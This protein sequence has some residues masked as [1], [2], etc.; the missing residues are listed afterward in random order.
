MWRSRLFWRL[1]LTTD[2][3]ITG[4]ANLNTIWTNA[5]ALVW[6]WGGGGVGWWW[7]WRK[8][9]WQW[10]RWWWWGSRW[11][12]WW[13][14]CQFKHHHPLLHTADQVQSEPFLPSYIFL[15]AISPFNIRIMC[16][17]D[18][19]I[20]SNIPL[21]HLQDLELNYSPFLATGESYYPSVHLLTMYTWPTQLQFERHYCIQ[22]KNPNTRDISTHTR[23][24]Q[25]RITQKHIH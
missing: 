4:R 9:S 23:V 19:R 6:R 21:Y 12:W 7:W 2:E 15:C 18:S 8:W 14:W 22:I 10:W 20:C 1:L 17:W 5:A 11:W 25:L 13:W 16:T 24:L 3:I